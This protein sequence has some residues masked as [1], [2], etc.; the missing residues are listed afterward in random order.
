[1][2]IFVKTLDDKTIML[3]VEPSDTIEN[4]KQKIQN[5]EWTLPDQQKTIFAGLTL[6]D[7]RSFLNTI[8]KK[9][10]LFT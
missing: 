8:F 7:S 1:M 5:I 9:K 2:Q 6:E 3:D 4:I 10:Q